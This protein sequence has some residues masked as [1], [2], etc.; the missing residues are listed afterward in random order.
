MFNYFYL[1]IY[2]LIQL[3]AFKGKI[4]PCTFLYLYNF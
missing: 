3:N 1:N 4:Q 2:T